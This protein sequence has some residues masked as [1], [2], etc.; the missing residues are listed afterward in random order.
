MYRAARSALALT[1]VAAPFWAGALPAVQSPQA[2]TDLVGPNP[3]VASGWFLGLGAADITAAGSGLTVQAI[4]VDPGNPGWNYPVPATPSPLFPRGYF[5]LV[6]YTGQVGSW[7]LEATDSSGTSQVSTHKLD[8]V[9]QLPLV[10]GLSVSGDLLNPTVH[11]TGVNPL[12]Y[13]SSC[14][15]AACVAGFDFFNYR[16]IVRDTA[17]TIFYQSANVRTDQATVWSLAGV[18]A[19]DTDYLIGVRLNMSEMEVVGSPAI[20]ENRSTT[21]L[22]YSTALVP[23]PSTYALL[24]SGLGLLVALGRCRARLEAASGSRR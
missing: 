2:Y 22:A 23:E 11:W 12:V 14:A 21:Y 17:G 10:T 3:Y 20:L 16:V 18:L 4:N 24:A 15:G 8:D 13:P 1:A 19:P 7:L 5:A 6:P 9:R